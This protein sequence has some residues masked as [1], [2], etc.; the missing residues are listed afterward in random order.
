LKSKD[1]QYQIVIQ[2]LNSLS[3]K[4]LETISRSDIAKKFNLSIGNV[5]V[6]LQ[7]YRLSNKIYPQNNKKIVFGYLAKL[8]EEEFKKMSNTKLS[9]IL[10]INKNTASAYKTK[11]KKLGNEKKR[12]SLIKLVFE[13]LDENENKRTSLDVADKYPFIKEELVSKYVFRW[14]RFHP[15]VEM[16]KGATGI[17]KIKKWEEEDL[18]FLRNS[19]Y[20]SYYEVMIELGKVPR[21]KKGHTTME[22]IESIKKTKSDD[23]IEA[24]N[25]RN[26]FL[27]VSYGSARALLEKLMIVNPDINGPK[28]KNAIFELKRRLNN[29][30]KDRSSST[31]VGTAIFLA[32][33]EVSQERASKM[34]IAFGKCTV[35]TLRTLR[36][37]VKMEKQDILKNY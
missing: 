23:E 13:F 35:V 10:G 30:G 28:T 22:Y 16:S 14:F 2:Y 33:K 12:K 26:A 18:E 9:K 15:D 4:E 31:V 21:A 29:M 20:K 25:N 3:K 19:N 7:G 34:M 5:G 8:T 36:E 6:Y 27:E 24:Y 37:L 11:F 1:K 32:N 17:A